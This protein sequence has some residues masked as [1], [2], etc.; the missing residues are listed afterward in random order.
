MWFYFCLFL[1]F[2]SAYNSNIFSFPYTE[3]VLCNI[4]VSVIICK[5]IFFSYYFCKILKKWQKLQFYLKWY[6]LQIRIVISH[7]LNN[8]QSSNRAILVYREKLKITVLLSNY[9]KLETTYALNLK[10]TETEVDGYAISVIYFFANKKKQ[11]IW[12]SKK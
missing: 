9:F 7:D 6:V 2:S 12:F 10:L 3:Y 11:L 4:S 1:I 5:N 8:W